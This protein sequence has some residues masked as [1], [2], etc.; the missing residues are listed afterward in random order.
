MNKLP[1]EQLEQLYEGIP[2]EQTEFRSRFLLII[3]QCSTCQ[4]Q[5]D[6][7]QQ[8]PPWFDLFW[9]VVQ[10][11]GVSIIVAGYIFRAARRGG[12]SALR[13]SIRGAVLAHY[14]ILEAIENPKKYMRRWDNSDHNIAVKDEMVERPVNIFTKSDDSM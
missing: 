5:Y 13:T 3:Q 4:N 9:Q 10:Y 2:S 8:R 6:H 7:E 11:L 12:E 14:D 1:I